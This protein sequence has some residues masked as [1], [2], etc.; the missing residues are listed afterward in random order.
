MRYYDRENNQLVYIQEAATPDFWDRQWEDNKL[1]KTILA[2]A[3]ERF[4][5][6]ITRR[7]LKP[8]AKI[9]EGG[10]G[11]GQFVYSLYSRGFD[12]YGVDYAAKTVAKVSALFPELKLSLGDVRNLSFSD[13]FFDGYWSVGVIEHFTEGYDPIAKEMFRVLKPGGVLFL[14]FPYMS[15]LR[16]LK[17][18]LG[19]YPLLTEENFDK[20]KFYQFALNSK[21]VIKRFESFGFELI[22]EKPYSG[23]KGLKDESGIFRPFFQRIYDNSS[24]PAKLVSYALTILFSPFTSH[25]TVLILRKKYEA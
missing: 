13:N 20:D 17:A 22:K 6:P 4:V 21:N 10:F 2:G 12:A 16:K 11:K 5:Y 7:Y 3:K 23:F 14:T 1:K 24:L 25:A 19:M 15:P 8:G 18:K 9:L